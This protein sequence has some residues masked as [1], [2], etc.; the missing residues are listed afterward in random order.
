[1]VR[2]KFF[3]TKYM[4]KGHIAWLRR[5]RRIIASDK[6]VA[7]GD[8]FLEHYEF[9]KSIWVYPEDDWLIKE[10]DQLEIGENGEYD[11]S[12]LSPAFKKYMRFKDDEFF[13]KAFSLWKSA[14]LI[15]G[16]KLD[17]A[18]DN[19]EER[20]QREL[21]TDEIQSLL[22]NEI[23]AKITPTWVKA[24][25]SSRKAYKTVNG[26]IKANLDKFTSFVTLTFARLENEEKYLENGLDFKLL[27]DVRDFEAVK[28]AFEDFRKD[29]ARSMKKKYDMKF[30]YI[31]VYEQHKD[32]VYH[33]HLLT[34]DIPAE[35]IMDTPEFLDTDKK[36][37]KKR[38]GKSI[39]KWK[40]G[41]SDIEEIRDKEKLSTYISKYISKNF[42]S[43]TDTEETY[44]EYLGKKKYFTSQGLNKPKVEYVKQGEEEKYKVI[45]KKKAMY[46]D[47]YITSYRN[48]Y[49][50]SE[51]KQTIYS[52]KKTS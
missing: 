39:E 44:K 28:K 31:A 13:N 32:G 52:K 18:L 20:Y 9:E 46:S 50:D 48:Y 42:Q 27:E 47:K 45:E 36:T 33:F 34:S 4:K 25:N 22:N 3:S 15:A 21:F 30:E 49:S 35:Y 29:L 17:R 51:I 2:Y 23:T 19:L 41:K 7:Y 26:L 10:L 6:V 38:N 5:S 1:M 37:G 24:K 14:D 11:Y 16:R 12:K 8:A 43:L 40:F